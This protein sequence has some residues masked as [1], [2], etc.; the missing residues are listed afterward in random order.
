MVHNDGATAV[1]SLPLWDYYSPACLENPTTDPDANGAGTDPTLG[2]LH[3]AD[4]GPLA[5]GTSRTVT[6]SFHANRTDAMYWK[7]G[8]WLDYAPKGMPD[9]DQK[10][11]QWDN[12]PGQGVGWYYCGPVAAANSLWWFDSKFEP[13]PIPPPAINDGYPLV[14]APAAALYDDH[15]PRNVQNFVN[16]LAGLMGTVPGQGT[17]VNNLAIGIA[18]HI[19]ATVGPGQYT[20][21]SP[22][23]A[24]PQFE[25]VE[26][27]VRRSED[28]IL[29]LGFWQAIDT[30]SGVYWERVGGHFVTVAGI[31][32]ENKLIA[33]SD[34]YNDRAEQGQPWYGRVL[35][36]P[37]ASLHPGAPT[38]E[39]HNDAKYASHDV[40]PIEATNSPGGTWGPKGYVNSSPPVGCPQIQNFEGQ[41]PSGVPCKP[42]QA[43]SLMT[44]V[45]FAV[46]VSPNT[47]TVTCDPTTNIA[48]V[49][50]AVDEAGMELPE[51]QAHAQ[52][53]I[54]QIDY[55]DAP[56][57]TYPTLKAS[58]GAAHT[59]VQGFYLGQSVDPEPNG[60]P[61]PAALGDD[62]NGVP[63]DEDGVAFLSPIV[64]GKQACVVVTAPAGG[65]L[66]AWIDFSSNGAWEHPGEHL[67]GGAS[68]TLSPGTNHVC[69][70]APATALPGSTFARFRLSRAGGLTPWGPAPDGEVE[71]YQITID[72]PGDVK[73][74]Q[75]PNPHLPGL[76]THDSGTSWL[77]GADDWQCKGGLVT[78][79]HWWG[80]YEM[81]STG[82]E[83]RGSGIKFFQLSIHAADST[84]PSQPGALLWSMD[85]PFTAVAETATGVSNLEGSP[86]YRYEYQL[87]V[88]FPQVP[89]RTYWF[90]VAAHSL[91]PGQPAIWRWQESSRGLPPQGLYPAAYR[92]DPGGSWSS[93]NS[94]MAFV[95][96]S[97]PAD[98]GDA[99]DAMTA[100]GYPTL[101]A[102]G[103]AA[104]ALVSGRPFMGPSVDSELDGQPNA[105][106]TGDDINLVYPGDPFPPGD[107][108]GVKF[109]TAIVPGK[110]ATL[111]V[112][113]TASPK[114]CKLNA[115]LD[116]NGNASWADA[117]EQI[118][119]DTPLTNGL[120]HTLTF[121]V[122]PIPAAKIGNTFARF[123]CSTQGGL[124]PGGAAEDGEVEDYRV[125]ITAPPMPPVV[126]TSIVDA[127]TL[128]LS[129]PKVT[130]D[131]YGNTRLADGYR[132]YWNSSPYW[133]PLPGSETWWL[134]EPGLPDPVTQ[135]ADDLGAPSMHHFYI[136]RAVYTDIWGNALES[137]DSNR[138]GEF[139][140][141]LVPGSP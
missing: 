91:V 62:N 78:D 96:T 111:K 79:L 61:H 124:A 100:P 108:N 44:E 102:S 97:K 10:Q 42:A 110:V 5:A 75:P 107:E 82:A 125:S 106:A 68:L 73:W 16:T 123:R 66:D 81:D 34:P 12:P 59:I 140:F 104:H 70:L 99:P 48:V 8:G 137:A 114:P 101:L 52:V 55:G 127:D 69:F 105:T 80:N 60:Q 65:A 22:P 126:T 23:V 90:D 119:T 87:V 85:V 139:E 36:N 56:D 113:M 26:R 94:D 89:G 19:T 51:V 15:S 46:A 131:T 115:W 118:F 67:F 35:P 88:P 128:R 4:L 38:G 41:N 120:G 129:W 9:F 141:T 71:D 63:D 117:G 74:V 122:P 6:V 25:W 86:I 50:G 45:E 95:V 32:S 43:I 40:Y 30:P 3:W 39:V 54:T 58:N 14:Q 27:E 7:E 98:L 21:T 29:L 17:N 11:D 2:I 116:F 1:A 13:N 77:T 24:K 132:I 31:D 53:H 112:D 130:T 103:G 72:N 135:N 92:T 20:V 33:F 84:A 83:K 133:T 93:T 109:L 64:Q 49:G 47:K 134:P 28:V 121:A 18:Q 138:E 57:P 37:H 76:H 136:V